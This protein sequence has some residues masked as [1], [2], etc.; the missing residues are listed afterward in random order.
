MSQGAMMGKVLKKLEEE[1]IR[2]N[3][4]ITKNQIKEIIK[5]YSN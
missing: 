5:Q 1:W 2:N 4:S 3:F